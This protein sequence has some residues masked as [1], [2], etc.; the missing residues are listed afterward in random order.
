MQKP[1]KRHAALP[2]KFS[3]RLFLAGHKTTSVH[4]TSPASSIACS[5]GDYSWVLQS[6]EKIK[7]ASRNST[8]WCEEH[9]LYV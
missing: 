2:D 4:I 8:I 1:N 7:E 3:R 5:K 9:L 6:E